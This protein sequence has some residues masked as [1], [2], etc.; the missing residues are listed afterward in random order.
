[1]L[2]LAVATAFF[3]TDSITSSFQ[4]GI[5]HAN[6]HPLIEFGPLFDQNQSRLAVVL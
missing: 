2:V 1:M 6:W 3:N 4:P 5:C